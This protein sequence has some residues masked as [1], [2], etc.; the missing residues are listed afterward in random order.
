MLKIFSLKQLKLIE[1]VVK[2]VLSQNLEI[3]TVMSVFK[4]EKFKILKNLRFYV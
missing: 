4:F 1:N 3:F 2:V